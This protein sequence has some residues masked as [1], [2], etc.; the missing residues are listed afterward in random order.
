LGIAGIV[1]NLLRGSESNLLRGGES[2]QHGPGEI[3]QPSGFS[4]GG[5][6]IRPA[7]VDHGT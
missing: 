2:A 6:Q 4:E 1:T 5:A 7:D 3:D